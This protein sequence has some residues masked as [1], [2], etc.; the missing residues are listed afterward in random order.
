MQEP[1]E[2]TSQVPFTSHEH[3]NSS[4]LPQEASTK[5]TIPEVTIPS[6]ASKSDYGITLKKII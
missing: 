4:N 6:R 2:N 3:I 5:S 1:L